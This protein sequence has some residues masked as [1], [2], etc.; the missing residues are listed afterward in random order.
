MHCLHRKKEAFT[1]VPERVCGQGWVCVQEACLMLRQCLA[2]SLRERAFEFRAQ[3]FALAS[4][5]PP[6]GPV[7]RRASVD[8]FA[9]EPSLDEESA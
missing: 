8:R 3:Q 6:R 5:P 2:L 7:A 1:V 4:T 9:D